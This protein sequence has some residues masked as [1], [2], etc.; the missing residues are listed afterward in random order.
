MI[1]NYVFDTIRLLWILSFVVMTGLAFYFLWWRRNNHFASMSIKQSQSD[2]RP[3]SMDVFPLAFETE[4]H[5]RLGWEQHRAGFFPKAIRHYTDSFD[6]E[7]MNL[8]ALMQ[9]AILHFDKG[10][11][12]AGK[13][14]LQDMMDNPRHYSEEKLLWAMVR[15]L[16]QHKH[17]ALAMPFIQRLLEIAPSNAEY[18]TQLVKMQQFV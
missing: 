14:Y 12:K 11:L 16:S 2:V 6:V 8:T 10:D 18:K 15:V 3:P 17:D 4:P 7:P 13:S 1:D 9:L 5:I